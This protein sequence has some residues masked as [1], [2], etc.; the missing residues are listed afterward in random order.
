[1]SNRFDTG[2]VRPGLTPDTPKEKVINLKCRNEHC[3]SF[4]AMEIQLTA[5]SHHGQR[6]YRCK[7]CNHSWGVSLGGYLDF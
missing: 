4:E 2:G 6:L 1:M 5:P 7:K 3:D